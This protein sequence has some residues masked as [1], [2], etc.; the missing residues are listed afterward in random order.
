[1][2]RIVTAI[3]ALALAFA[4]PALAQSTAPPSPTNPTMGQQPDQSTSQPTQPPNATQP[5]S[6][7]AGATSSYG[8][9]T[10][11][12]Q[13]LSGTI[14]SNGK[15][16]TSSNGTYNISNASDAKEFANQPVTVEYEMDGSNT[17][18]ITKVMLARPQ[19]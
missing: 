8:A 14:S 18:R 1:M 6:N 12:N 5:P 13:H 16:F 7:Q 4:L 11:T 2:T 15:T 3:L 10:Q 19:P 17:I 9:N